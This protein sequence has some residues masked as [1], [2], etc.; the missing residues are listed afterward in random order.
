MV[1]AILAPAAHQALLAVNDI[2]VIYDGAILAVAGVSL[3]VGQGDIVAL[4]GANGAGKSTT[5]KAISGLV[6]ADRA[7]VSRGQIRFQGQDTAG[8]AAHALARE[9]IVHVL[10]GRHVFAHLTIEENLRCAGF[11]RNPTRREL[12]QQL[13]RIYAWFPRLKTKRKAQAGLTS[14]GEQQMLAI[15]R[16][17]MTTP[18]LVL[19]DEPS[20]GLAPIIVEEIFAIVAQLNAQEGM[21]FLIAEQNINVALRHASYAYILE[22]GRVVGEG[23]AAELAAQEDIQHF[24]LGG[25]AG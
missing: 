1:H 22:N 13:E 8:V 21:S 19:L 25:K 9:G 20:M 14:G 18:R 6:Q 11:L 12:E 4:L 17:L 16:A 3:Q 24:Y 10:E 7:Q 23:A 15:G 2:E 5:L